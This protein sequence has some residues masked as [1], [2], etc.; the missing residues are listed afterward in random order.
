MVDTKD[1]NG[2][3]FTARRDPAHE[4]VQRPL[5]PR[6]KNDE[7]WVVPAGP[8]P[9]THCSMGTGKTFRAGHTLKVAC[10]LRQAHHQQGV[11]AAHAPE[12]AGGVGASSSGR[13]V[14]RC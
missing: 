12:A 11:R 4:E 13:W 14:C 10:M 3:P 2:R 5:G 8:A 9:H 6:P 7:R 1:A